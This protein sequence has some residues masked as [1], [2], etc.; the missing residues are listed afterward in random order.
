MPAS[1]RNQTGFQ[2]SPRLLSVRRSVP[3]AFITSIDK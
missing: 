2:G 3:S 1:P